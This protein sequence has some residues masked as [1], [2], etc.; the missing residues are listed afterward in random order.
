MLISHTIIADHADIQRWVCLAKSGVAPSPLTLAQFDD[1]VIRL[2]QH[3]SVGPESLNVGSSLRWI[4]EVDGI[5]RVL[6]DFVEFLFRASQGIGRSLLVLGATKT[7]LSLQQKELEGTRW[8][9]LQADI[10]RQP[11]MRVAMSAITLESTLGQLGILRRGLPA[12]LDWNYARNESAKQTTGWVA[13]VRAADPGARRV[14]YRGLW[15]GV[16]ALAITQ[17]ALILL[18]VPAI[19]SG[20]QAGYLTGYSLLG[21]TSFITSA[22]TIAGLAAALTLWVRGA[23]AVNDYHTNRLEARRREL[24]W[25]FEQSSSR[26]VF[27]DQEDP[28]AGA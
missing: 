19:W 5:V 8:G 14:F 16:V 17:A 24:D 23:A 1:L 11:R 20:Y 3:A 26:S 7:M 27:A 22:V 2:R 28:G 9:N 13:R 18:I 25:K 21:L 10:S 4:A 15:A 12:L 6:T